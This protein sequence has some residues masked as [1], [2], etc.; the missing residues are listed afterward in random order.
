MKIFLH[1][2]VISVLQVSLG[3]NDVDFGISVTKNN[4]KLITFDKA[5]E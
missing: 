1:D 5:I 2:I 3:G 4:S